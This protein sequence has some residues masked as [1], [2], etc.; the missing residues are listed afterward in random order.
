VAA[1]TA[2]DPRLQPGFE[3]ADTSIQA[4]VPYYGVYD[5]LNREGHREEEFVGWASQWILKADPDEDHEAWRLASPIELVH[6]D[7]P[8]FLVVHGAMDTLT[9]PREAEQFAGRLRDV[10]RQPVAFAELPGA[11]HAFDVFPSLRTA[12][13]VHGVVRFL[14]HTRA[15]ASAVARASASSPSG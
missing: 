10:S 7:A 12:R 3:D 13:V 15:R 1:L 8:P 6:E 4:A 2:D 11:Q 14:E 9:S 5:F